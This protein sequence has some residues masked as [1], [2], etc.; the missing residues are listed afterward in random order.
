MTDSS[1]KHD[2]PVPPQYELIEEVVTTRKYR[3]C[4]VPAAQPVPATA[5]EAPAPP[6]APPAEGCGCDIDGHDE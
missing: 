6:S 2:Q 3:P 1:K 5:P 4:P